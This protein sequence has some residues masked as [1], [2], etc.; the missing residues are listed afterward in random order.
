MAVACKNNNVCKG[1]SV[2]I[3][4][5]PL[6]FW[7]LADSNKLRDQVQGCITTLINSSI[8]RINKSGY[9]NTA[10]IYDGLKTQEYEQLM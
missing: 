10:Q 1:I 9:L 5:E 3:V 6:Y 7:W 2:T 4:D 8:L